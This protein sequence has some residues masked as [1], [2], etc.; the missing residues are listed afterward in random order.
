MTLEKLAVLWSGCHRIRQQDVFR[1]CT[2]KFVPILICGGS[3]SS[4]DAFVMEMAEY[5][6]GN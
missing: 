3:L 5:S 4:L 1:N 2:L 6:T